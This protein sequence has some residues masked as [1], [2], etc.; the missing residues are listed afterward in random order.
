VSGLAS[1]FEELQQLKVN[2][3]SLK[4]G[5]NLTTSAGRLI[6]N[7]LASVAQYE[8][9]IRGERI[10]AGQAVAKAN[11]K[12][13]GGS[14]KGRRVKVTVEQE[15]TVQKLHKDGESISNIARSVSLSRP[16]IYRLLGN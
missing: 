2:F 14:V 13:W 12:K 7:V 1:L 10:L 9:E 6:A 8:T 16:T 3:V 5:I 15:R 11:G 4:D